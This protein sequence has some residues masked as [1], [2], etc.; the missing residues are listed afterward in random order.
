MRPN[1]YFGEFLVERGKIT[2]EQLSRLLATQRMVRD[3]IGMI[4]VRE[5]LLGE[6]DL[7][8]NLAEFHGI[9]LYTRGLESIERG[10]V[11]AIP[12]KLSLKSNVLPVG[13]GEHGELLLACSGPLPQAMLQTISRLCKRQVRLVMTSQR[14]LKKMQNLFFSSQFDTT[15]KMDRP[16][17]ADDVGFIVELLEK[18]MV[19][20]VNRG[21]SDVHL[22]PEKSELIVRLRVDGML[23][24]TERLPFDLAAKLV[25]RIKVLA[26]MNIAERRKPQDGSF[27]FTPQILDVEMDGVNVRANILPVVNGEK[28]VLRILPPHDEHID[29][30]ALGMGEDDLNSFK[31]HLRLP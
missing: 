20:A 27:Y 26:G 30:D 22:E 21:A 29:L 14:Q 23:H 16:I 4:A 6:E 9:P 18:L 11:N 15:I 10:I 13:T 1:A 28:A 12:M 17:E 31:E 2:R 24:Q 8:A 7:T 19:R 25:S 3:K 5:G